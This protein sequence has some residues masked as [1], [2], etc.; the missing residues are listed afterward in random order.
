MTTESNAAEEPVADRHLLGCLSEPSFVWATIAGAIAAWVYIVPIAFDAGACELLARVRPSFAM[1]IYTP[2]PHFFDDRTAHYASA[3]V[4]IAVAFVAVFPSFVLRCIPWWSVAMVI[5]ALILGLITIFVYSP[6]SLAIWS[7]LGLVSAIGSI[8]VVSGRRP[9]RFW[10]LDANMVRRSR[11]FLSILAFV[12]VV[13][14]FLIIPAAAGAAHASIVTP[15]EPTY[16]LLYMKDA[17]SPLDKEVVE[18]VA[19]TTDYLVVTLSP[20]VPH[21]KHGGPT[22]LPEEVTPAAEDSLWQI[23]MARFYLPMLIRRDSIDAIVP[24]VDPDVLIGML[25]DVFTGVLATTQP[26]FKVGRSDDGGLK[27]W[28]EYPPVTSQPAAPQLGTED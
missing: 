27:I 11:V 17:G 12:V 20:K 24:S 18:L 22:S 6:G 16:L 13:E 23:S 2:Y 5:L 19:S 21:P 10:S 4:T 28:T 8:Y 25:R 9:L 26:V 3:I 1:V 14:F 7:L 15:R